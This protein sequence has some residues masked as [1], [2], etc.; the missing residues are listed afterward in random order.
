M[1]KGISSAAMVNCVLAGLFLIQGKTVVADEP[2]K[3]VLV[4]SHR[5][6]MAQAK[7]GETMKTDNGD[8]ALFFPAAA[9]VNQKIAWTFDAPLPP[10][11][12]QVDLDLYHTGGAVSVN[13]MLLFEGDGG[14]AL[15]NVDFYFAGISKGSSTRSF[16]FYSF[17]PLA[18][19][20]LLKSAQRNQDTVAVSSIKIASG[21]AAALDKLQFVLQLPVN[22]VEVSLPFPLPTGLYVM[23]AAKPVALNWILRD[24]SSFTTPQAAEIRVYLDGPAQ[25][26]VTSGGPVSDLRLTR[27]PPSNSPDMSSAGD[28][29]LTMV[30]DPTKIETRTLTLIGYTGADVPKLD[31]LPGGKTVALVT[32]WDDGP[33]MDI[34]LTE[35]L[36]KYGVKGTLFMNS[37]SKMIGQLDVLEAKG[38]EIGSHSWS[39]PAF[40]NSSPK[41]CMDEAV[42]MRRLL[43]KKLGHPVV[44]FAY[45]F[46][47]QPAFDVDGDYV[48]RSLRQAGYWSGRATS[49]GDNLID[50]IPEPL[51]MRPNFHFNA[52]AAKT[53][54][55]LEELSRKP[56]SILYFWGHSY[57]LSG[58]GMK[59]LEAVLES[60]ANRPDVW[61]ATLGELMAWKFMRG[62]MR[63]KAAGTSADGTSFTLEMPWLHPYML[64]VPVSLTLPEG[65]TAVSWQGQQML[66]KDRRVQLKW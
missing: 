24:G 66:A 9:Q 45:P 19:L 55:K 62:Q 51:A 64:Q 58:D 4:P 10:G 49:S 21:S 14:V 50:A 3:S 37:G 60:V 11:L 18:G 56:G 12:W 65:V 26:S 61:Y 16:G 42:G 2:A 22:G 5:L 34:Q 27:Y 23:N 35:C 28:A 7:G 29:P 15:G 44:S 13:E 32:S 33:L 59:T 20:S 54:A 8:T 25:P 30:V 31:L 39:H 1:S 48:L 47:Y 63:I 46:N 41:R 43:E 17:K 6:D 36:N 52:G 38:M 57:E 53:K 40:Y